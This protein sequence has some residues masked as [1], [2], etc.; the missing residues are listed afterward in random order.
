MS[1]VLVRAAAGK[2]CAVGG[3]SVAVAV[4]VAVAAVAAAVAVAVG[5]C[6]ET[7]SLADD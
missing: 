4:E 7:G 3:G 1:G 2:V 6:P 5:T